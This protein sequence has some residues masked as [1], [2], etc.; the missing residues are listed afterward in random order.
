[1]YSSSQL[2]V[3]AQ[4]WEFYTTAWGTLEVYNKRPR[5]RHLDARLLGQHN[6]RAY[7]GDLH[8]GR[9]AVVMPLDSEDG[10]TS[11]FVFPVLR[12]KKQQMY[13]GHF[14]VLSLVFFLFFGGGD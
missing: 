6:C 2:V 13:A 14:C 8:A 10:W 4:L 11:R 5:P 1:M 7:E 9:F 3:V 12:I